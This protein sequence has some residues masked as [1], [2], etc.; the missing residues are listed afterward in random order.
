MLYHWEESR[1]EEIWRQVLV[2]EEA[3]QKKWLG[4]KEEGW[5]G[6]E[7][8]GEISLEKEGG[9]LVIKTV[10]RQSFFHSPTPRAPGGR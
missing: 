7:E 5:E 4:I 1:L 2:R 6:I 9:N 8:K 10:S 3:W